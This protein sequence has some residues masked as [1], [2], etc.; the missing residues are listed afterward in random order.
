ML[1]GLIAGC[2]RGRPTGLRTDQPTK[3]EA[4]LLWRSE[5]I[6]GK[7][8]EGTFT[9]N[10]SGVVAA[11]EDETRGKEKSWALYLFTP[12]NT[13]QLTNGLADRY[14]QSCGL[15]DEVAFV[16][17]QDARVVPGDSVTSLVL[18]DTTTG[19]RRRI[20]LPKGFYWAPSWSPDGLHIA[21]YAHVS[22]RLGPGLG[23]VEVANDSLELVEVPGI[24]P[25]MSGGPVWSSDGNRILTLSRALQENKQGW[26]LTVVDVRK[27]AVV[28]SWAIQEQGWP[29]SQSFRP[30]GQPVF[31]VREGDDERPE[32]AVLYQCRQGFGPEQV[33]ILAAREG[34]LM[35]APMA[36]PDGEGM[37]VGT[38]ALSSKGDVIGSEILW[39]YRGRQGAIAAPEGESCA[40]VAWSRDSRRLAVRFSRGGMAELAVYALPEAE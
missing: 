8:C 26:N 40:V 6:P 20:R 9:G 10:G 36:S 33:A 37:A 4:R 34:W 24:S 19:Q 38:T 15:S 22:S 39:T 35:G 2:T 21:A 31:C 7:P 16:D 13:V 32:R 14:P 27:M 23:I 12:S 25:G 28:E 18:L 1:A 5:R 30:G 11:V 29:A 3:S 17:L